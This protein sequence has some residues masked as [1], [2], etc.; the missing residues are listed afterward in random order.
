MWIVQKGA[1]KER[2]KRETMENKTVAAI[3]KLFTAI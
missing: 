2:K 3:Y 1:K